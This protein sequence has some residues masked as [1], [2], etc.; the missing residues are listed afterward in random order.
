M[1][2]PPASPAE[3]AAL[4]IAV[5]ATAT[6]LRARRIPN[7]LT[8]TGA[9][10]ALTFWSVAAG[11]SGALG[12]LAGWAVGLLLFLPLYALRGMGAGD[13]KLLACIGAWLGAGPVLRVA[14]YTVLAGGVL[15]LAVALHRRYLRTA[16]DNMLVVLATWRTSGIRPVDGVTLESAA[17]P[18]LAYAIPITVGTVLASWLR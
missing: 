12:S 4:A 16:A 6:D 9:L 15:A 10:A 14:L 17:G 3:L 5:V 7:V 18:R 2:A 1:W 8:L 13:V 11:A